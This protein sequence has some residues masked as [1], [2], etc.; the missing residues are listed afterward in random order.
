MLAI[1]TPIGFPAAY[2][3][4]LRYL[5]SIFGKSKHNEVKN[6]IYGGRIGILMHPVYTLLLK[7]TVNLDAT[8]IT[9]SEP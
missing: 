3:P 9:L 1:V 6:Q 2:V 5:A 7:R 8:T 4:C